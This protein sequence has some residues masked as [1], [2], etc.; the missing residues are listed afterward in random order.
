MMRQKRWLSSGKVKAAIFLLIWCALMAGPHNVTRFSAAYANENGPLSPLEPQA[1]RGQPTGDTHIDN[2][3]PVAN[4]LIP[5]LIREFIDKVPERFRRIDFSLQLET[6][7]KTRYY[8]E[9]VQPLY[10][11]ADRNNTYF[12]QGRASFQHGAQAYNIGLGYR[13]L[14]FNENLLAGI[15]AFY[16]WADPNDHSRW[17]VGIEAIGKKAEFRAN[18]YWALSDERLVNNSTSSYEAAI[19]GFDAE[20]GAPIPYLPWARVYGSYFWYDHK[21]GE[22]REGYK[23][24]GEVDITSFLRLDLAA[25]DDNKGPAEYYVAA[26]LH[27]PWGEVWQ[28]PALITGEKGIVADQAWPDRDLKKLTLNRVVRSNEIA[29]E[30]WTKSGSVTIEVGRGN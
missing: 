17:G 30:K 28:P 22:N 18:S 15:N 24:R 10:Q 8:I 16:D 11:D 12:L 1:S 20:I 7:E 4:A 2:L 23:A 6:D 5:P 21:H 27:F 3:Y 29:L 14:L 26:A 25:W 13:R 19:S 9:T